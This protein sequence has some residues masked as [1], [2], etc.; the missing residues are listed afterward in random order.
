MIAIVGGGVAGMAAALA[1]APRPV[2]LISRAGPGGESSSI[3][4]QGGIA[5]TLGAGDSAADHLAD[6]LAAGDGLCDADLARDILA[7]AG[8]AIDF[9]EHHG[10]RF[11][12]RD[13]TFAFGLEAAHS[14]RRILHARDSTGAE[15]VRALASAVA[16][17]TSISLHHADVRRILT[18]GGGVTGLL[19]GDGT[20]LAASHILLATG[21][22]GGLYTD[23]TNPPGHL[24]QGIALA[25]RAGGINHRFGLSDAIMIKDN[26]VAMAGGIRPAIERARIGAGHMVKIEVEVDTLD[27]LREAMTVG[28]NVV[29]LDNMTPDM[30]RAATAIVGGRALTEAS[31]GIT[32]ETAAEIAVTGVNLISVG[33]ITHSAPILDI[34]LDYS[35]ESDA[36]FDPG[37]HA[38]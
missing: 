1:L 6:T 38:P 27:Q 15:I 7:M 18:D 13:G 2:V 12:R 14:R 21:G 37:A 31:G 10:V 35:T 3:L 23:T 11:D 33:W 32:P 4:A 16:G 29:L 5:A 17:C 8:E 9:L 28:V 22:L 24:G 26:H 20:V 19:L 34:G 30:L 25:A 36:G